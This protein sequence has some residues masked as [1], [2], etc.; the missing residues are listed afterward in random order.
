MQNIVLGL[1]LLKRTKAF[2]NFNTNTLT[3][4][5]ENIS[6]QLLKRNQFCIQAIQEIVVPPKQICVYE[7][8]AD[9]INCGDVC[10]IS[11]EANSIKIFDP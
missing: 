6:C 11:I 10:L 1:D 3:F 2:I 8:K 7:V 5:E 4:P 9:S